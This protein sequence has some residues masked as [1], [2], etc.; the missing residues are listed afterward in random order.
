MSSAVYTRFTGNA[1]EREE[2]FLALLLLFQEGRDFVALPQLE[3]LLERGQAL[4]FLGCVHRH[5]R[6]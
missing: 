4:G 5:L 1:A 3:L 2:L 6:K